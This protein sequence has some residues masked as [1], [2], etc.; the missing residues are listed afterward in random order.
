MIPL[1]LLKMYSSTRYLTGKKISVKLK[2]NEDTRVRVAIREGDNKGC[3]E[4]RQLYFTVL[5]KC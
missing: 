4:E 2:K 3:S 1:E 5:Q